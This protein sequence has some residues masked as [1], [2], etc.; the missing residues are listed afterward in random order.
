MTAAVVDRRETPQVGRTA[1]L[2][3]V[4]TLKGGR[5]V[6]THAY[7]EPPFRAGRC[8]PDGDGLHMILASSAPGIFGGD[9][10]TQTVVVEKGA[11]VRLSSQSAA[12]LHPAPDAAAA[13][14]RSTYEVADGARL[15]CRWDP[16]IPFAG[17][18]LDQR[19]AI[20]LAPSAELLWSD[21]LM[22]GRSGRGERWQFGSVGHELR[23]SRAGVLEYLE[24]YRLSPVEEAVDRPW[25]TADAQ[26]FGTMIAS[27]R[28]VDGGEPERL[29]CAIEC[30]GGVR[31]AA[32]R[33]ADA[34]LVVRL[35]S[36]SGARF[37]DA[38]S[39]IQR[40]VLELRE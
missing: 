19:I 11:R 38:R 3:L 31:I 39:L 27:G 32:D 33:L 5:T 26:F 40:M 13:D 25:R 7:A 15:Q 22:S 12:Q 16:L 1:R 24:R 35:M 30:A 21:A 6:L 23:V 28:A 14:L 37:H 34:L 9:T 4:F 8:F 29:S 2:E 20:A 17:A 10:L 18:V 36:Q